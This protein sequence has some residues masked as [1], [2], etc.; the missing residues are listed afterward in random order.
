MNKDV[1]EDVYKD[2]F[3][4]YNVKKNEE[5]EIK[6]NTVD[7]SNLL[8]SDESLKLLNNIYQYMV[9]YKD[10]G[11]VFLPFSIIIE[12]NNKETITRVVDN[13]ISMITETKYINSNNILKM[14]F[15]NLD[16][17]D[18]FKDKD[19][20]VL[21]DITGI[22]LKDNNYIKKLFFTLKELL[23]N[24][25][26]IVISGTKEEID[27]FFQND[28]SLKDKYFPFV[29]SGVNPD[30]N[31]VY[32]EV[33]GIIDKNSELDDEFKI[34]ILDYITNTF[35]KTDMDYPSYRDNLCREIS[36]NHKVPVIESTKTIDEVF[37]ELNEL[38]GLK[39]VKKT[40]YELVD[41][42]NFI[43]KNKDFNLKSVNLHMVFLGNP[44]TGKT[45]VARLVSNILYELGFIKQNKLLEVTVKDLVAEYVG[46]TAPKVMNVVE[47]AMGGV[48]FIDE[49]YALASTNDSSYNDEAIATL[50]KAMEDNRDNLVVIFAGYTK[51]MQKFLDSN[52][53]IVSRIGY[54]F[55]FDDYTED[56]LVEIFKGMVT[57][58]GFVANDDAILKLR[59]IIREY[60]DTKNFGN[61]RFVR[62]VY[63]KTV[64]K[65]ASNTKNK[66]RRD[67]LKTITKD[68]ISVDNLSK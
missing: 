27:L 26:S 67:I 5:V 19:I 53:G 56:E 63:E 7:F 58:A 34:S 11:K 45:T 14:S 40:L 30:V 41:Y 39:K 29:I 18:V 54:T 31:D 13:F 21:S 55:E 42:M 20:I 10:G 15:Y 43:K 49:A 61:A 36:F 52:S 12:S 60:K 16:N 4:D 64:I 44:G 35:E 25:K 3:G 22:N 8:V 33:L 37:N 32:N 28:N 59:D 48:L 17:L 62:N 65:H 24:K 68:D 2:F 38:V 9:D 57:K 47:K 1:L 51:E 46:Q 66:K 6:S 23:E 50:I